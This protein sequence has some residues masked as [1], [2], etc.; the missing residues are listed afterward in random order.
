M[1]S[2]NYFTKVYKIQA[3]L[4]SANL[5]ICSRCV[6]VLPWFVK[7]P[8]NSSARWYDVDLP[9]ED[10]KLWLFWINHRIAIANDWDSVNISGI[11][12]G[13]PPLLWVFVVSHGFARWARQHGCEIAHSKPGGTA[14][15]LRVAKGKQG[16]GSGNLSPGLRILPPSLSSLFHIWNNK[17]ISPG[18]SGSFLEVHAFFLFV[19]VSYSK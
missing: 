8:K 3:R 9:P 7:Q 10:V 13:F 19:T 2:I 16:G 17:E 5:W 4:A 6:I 11:T 1:R 14:G 15:G 12:T 18:S